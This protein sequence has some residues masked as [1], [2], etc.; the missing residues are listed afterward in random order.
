MRSVVFTLMLFIAGCP[1]S[2][3]SDTIQNSASANGNQKQEDRPS[4]RGGIGAQGMLCLIFPTDINKYTRDL[5]GSIKDEFFGFNPGNEPKEMHWG[6]GYTMKAEFRVLNLLQLE[7]YS[8]H[9]YA[10]PLQVL[11]DEAPGG[12]AAKHSIKATYK[13]QLSY[14]ETGVS[15]LYVPGSKKKNAFL[16]VG[17]GIGFMEGRFTESISGYEQLY[18]AYTYLENTRTFKGTTWSFHGTVGLTFV[19]WHFLELELV[20]NGRYARIKTLTDEQGVAF[21]NA[22]EDHEPVSLNFSGAD[23]RFG[24]KFI[25]P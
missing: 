3:S 10:F 24:C 25:F 13:F 18:G 1:A 4:I 20:L 23:L 12:I 22:Y 9:F 14:N 21:T 19:P 6:Y 8:D 16:I 17:G 5:Y 15:L 11:F 7:P 2:F